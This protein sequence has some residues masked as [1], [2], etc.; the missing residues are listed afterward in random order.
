LGIVLGGGDLIPEPA[1]VD[2]LCLDMLWVDTELV[3]SEIELWGLLILV[4]FFGT[5]F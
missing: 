2:T 3:L 4:L 1:V 5:G